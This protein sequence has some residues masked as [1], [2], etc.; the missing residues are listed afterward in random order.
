MVMIFSKLRRRWILKIEAAVL[1]IAFGTVL[2]LTMT[3]GCEVPGVVRPFLPSATFHQKFNLRAVDFFDD[4]QIV[5]LCEAIEDNDLKEMKRLIGTGADINTIG[6]GGVTPLFWAFPDNKL[7][8]FVLLLNNGAD[9]NIRLTSNLDLPKVFRSGD[10]VMH[11]AA[12]SQFRISFEI[13]H[14]EVNY[15]QARGRE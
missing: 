14:E 5:E 6:K 12:R 9:P 4:E 11:L 13:A 1:Q 3:L 7:E 15:G 10:T 8:R 2:V